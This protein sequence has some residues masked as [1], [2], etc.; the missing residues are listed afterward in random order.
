[1]ISG[2]PFGPFACGHRQLHA[3]PSISAIYSTV[4]R[5]SFKINKRWPDKKI[6]LPSA[7]HI[8]YISRPMQ[9]YH[10]QADLIWCDVTFW[11]GHKNDHVNGFPF[12]FFVVIVIVGSFRCKEK[13]IKGTGPDA[14]PYQNVTDP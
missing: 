3:T 4:G 13:N 7:I 1:M 6:F 5:T 8:L 10:F 14:D 2:Y 9:P 12:T 11:L